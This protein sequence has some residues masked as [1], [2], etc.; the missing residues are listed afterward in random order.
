MGSRHC[1]GWGALL[2]LFWFATES[3]QCFCSYDG[4]DQSLHHAIPSPWP[5]AFIV[6]E[7]Q[8]SQ[9]HPRWCF[10]WTEVSINPSNGTVTTAMGS[11]N[12]PLSQRWCLPWWSRAVDCTRLLPWC[13]RWWQLCSLGIH[14]LS[15]DSVGINVPLLSSGFITSNRAQHWQLTT[16][17]N[18]PGFFQ[19]WRCRWCIPWYADD[20]HELPFACWYVCCCCC[21]CNNRCWEPLLHPSKHYYLIHI[22]HPFQH[23]L[24]KSCYQST[25]L[26]LWHKL[27]GYWLV[28][29]L[30]GSSQRSSLVRQ[31]VIPPIFQPVHLVHNLLQAFRPLF[32]MKFF[33]FLSRLLSFHVPLQCTPVFFKPL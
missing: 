11:R 21:C 29:M 25:F 23:P 17:D 4:M 9:Q 22:F 1:Q 16:S 7:P 32:R 30:L 2:L 27:I 10:L 8:Q 24:E 3:F 18:K 14:G 33:S 6:M 28:V 26:L 31:L 12:S 13:L 15:V 5:A 20:A 19:L